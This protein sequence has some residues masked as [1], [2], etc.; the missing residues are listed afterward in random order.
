LRQAILKPRWIPRLAL[1]AFVCFAPSLQAGS[2]RSEFK[3]LAQ[4]FEDKH[5]WAEACRYYELALREN[6]N[7]SDCREALQRCI[8]RYQQVR[9]LT[10]KTYLDSL[11]KLTPSQA[12]DVYE[13][14]FSVVAASYADREKA[15]PNSLFQ[16]GVEEL[17]FALDTDA[18]KSEFLSG[19]N[20]AAMTRSKARLDGWAAFKLQYRG[21][22]TAQLI[23]AA[24]EAAREQVRAIVH[25]FQEEGL[26]T[27]PRTIVAVSLEFAAGA[28]NAL[29]EYTLLYTPGYFNDLQ[30][31]LRG[32]T[33]GVGLEL[34]SAAT[35]DKGLAISRVYPQGPAEEAGLVA[36]VRVKAIDRQPVADLTPQAAAL[37]LRGE[38][39]TV[40]ELEV[41]YPGRTTTDVVK[42]ARRPVLLTSV[43]ARMLPSPDIG[44]LR[45]FHFQAST[46]QEVKEAVAF[47]QGKRAQGLILDLRGNPGGNFE[48]AVRV[49]ELFL[50]EGVIVHTQGAMDR[51]NHPYISKNANSLRLPLV[52]LI[53]G[54]TASAAEALA[55]ALKE[56]SRARLIG[57]ATFGK[58]SIQVLYTLDKAP[59]QRMPAGIRLT[60]GR[61]SASG[62][63]VESGRGIFPDEEQD[64]AAALDFAHEYLR[65]L[66]T[67]APAAAAASA[68]GMTPMAPAS[69]ST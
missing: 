45:I 14:T 26:E 17:R 38:A 13:Q 61:F 49:A 19:A 35:G 68:G 50:S 55:G 32:K 46:S 10:D 5:D 59:L 28:C 27:R 37:R 64:P 24:R 6:R 2:V 16:R 69:P 52:V 60:V 33:V 36:G 30:A 3:Q 21:T 25:A 51:Y 42:L 57:Q 31:T 47:L 44:Y 4:S 11:G 39:N 62:K 22:T 43:E 20:A 53:D 8:R 29:D 12:L 41:Q 23:V 66:L 67:P 65:S 58:C 56:R 1:V 18:F 15:D 54:E 63:F 34:T 48:A 40:V 7:Q 9:R